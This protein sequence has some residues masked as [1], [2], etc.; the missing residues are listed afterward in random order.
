MQAIGII[1]FSNSGKTTLI[2]RLSECLEARGLRVAIAKHTHHELDKPDTDTALLMGPKRTIVGLSNTGEGRGEA[3]IHWGHPCF[4]R[5]MV[6]LL[7]ADI[8]L[9]E[10]G[11]S[12]GWLPRILCLRTTS[13]LLAALPEGCKALRPELALATYGDNT[14]PGLP[15]Y[16]AEELD[17]L[18]DL[19]LERA[20]LLPGLDCGACGEP[21]CAAMTARIVAGEKQTTDC[22][23]SRGSIELA[24]NGQPVGLNPF[25]AQILSGGIRGMLEALKGVTPGG[26]ITIRLRG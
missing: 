26:E 9:V 3:M 25:A 8:L 6:P 10:G 19:I 24:V 1:G 20:F 4:L 7:D 13:E 2:S 14:L 18:V 15:S 22:A 17:R 21:D 23:A 12:L 16:T 11:K 5:D